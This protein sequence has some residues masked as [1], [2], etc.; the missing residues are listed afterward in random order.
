MAD[1]SLVYVH[2][3]HRDVSF[4]KGGVYEGGPFGFFASVI[5][6][7]GS[8]GYLAF[9]CARYLLGERS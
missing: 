6:F 8:L 3:Y 7:L 4:F 1:C 2:G 9:F 5:F